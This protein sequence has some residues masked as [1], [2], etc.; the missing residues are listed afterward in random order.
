MIERERLAKQYVNTMMA[1]IEKTISE[2]YGD[3]FKKGLDLSDLD[4]ALGECE[5]K[6]GLFGSTYKIQKVD[7]K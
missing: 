2:V 4:K 5:G 6:F 1:K 3:I 7:G